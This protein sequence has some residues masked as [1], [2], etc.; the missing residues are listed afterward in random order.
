MEAK[1]PRDVYSLEHELFRETVRKFFREEVDPYYREWEKD[2]YPREL[3][4][5]AGK[6]GILQAGIPEEYGGMGGDFIHHAILHEEQ[7][8]SVGGAALGSGFGI[9]GS[10]YLIFE[11]GT[12]EQKREYLPRYATGELVAEVCFTEPHSGSDLG[13]IKTMS[14]RDGDDYLLN[15]S[16]TWVSGG[17]H[18]DMFPV[19]TKIELDDGKVGMA[20]VLIE[21]DMPGVTV[22][23]RIETSHK[24]AAIEAE[25]FFDD[26]RFPKSKILGGDPSGAFKRVMSCL[27]NQRVAEAAR[28]LASSEYAF[29]LTV[30]F[31][32]SRQAF[33]QTVFDFQNTQFALADMLTQ[34]RTLRPFVDNCLIKARDGTLTNLDSSMAKLSA[35][36]VEWKVMD[37]ALQLH[38]GMGF[39]HDMPISML[40]SMAR[41][42]RVYLGTSEIQR[43]T[44]AKSITK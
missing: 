21:P 17:I 14:R 13:A 19:F 31:T 34:I 15:G 44:I 27:V 5:T 7:G 43:V 26:V 8:Y 37:Q 39:A 1:Q 24:S 29:D 20:L 22:S 23:K 30:E 41:V 18:C 4:K 12:E 25:V 42:H 3:F 10:S 28:F 36:E 16:K 35:S 2:G 33:G 11:G 9:D 40:W 32:Q 6:Y 38:G